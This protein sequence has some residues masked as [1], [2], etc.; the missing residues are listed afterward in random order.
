[1]KAERADTGGYEV[2]GKRIKAEGKRQRDEG[3]KAGRQNL[4]V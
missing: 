2:I 4:A 1:L 3:W